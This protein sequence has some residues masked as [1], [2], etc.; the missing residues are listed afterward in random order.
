[1]LTKLRQVA[2]PRPSAVLVKYRNQIL[3]VAREHKATDVRVFGS[4]ARGEDTSGSDIDLLVTFQPEADVFDLAD[5]IIELEA[6]TSLRV[7]VVSDGGLRSGAEHIKAEA[8][9]L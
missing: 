7:D 3:R 9:A 5:L 4:V 8:V 1:M 2:P 6:L